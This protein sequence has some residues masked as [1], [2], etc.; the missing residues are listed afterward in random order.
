MS[1][2]TEKEDY[3]EFIAFTFQ[4]LAWHLG[5]LCQPLIVE[6]TC[7]RLLS[8]YGFLRGVGMSIGIVP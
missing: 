8:D 7:Y 3:K 1:I 2:F 6:A 4:P 5:Y